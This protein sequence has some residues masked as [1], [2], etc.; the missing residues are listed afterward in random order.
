[1]QT[2]CEFFG[3]EKG[4]TALIGGGGKTSTMFALTEHLKTKGSVILCTT[5]HILKPS[6]YPYFAY[7]DAPLGFGQVVST[8][9]L[10]GN[11]LTAPQ[12]NFSELLTLADYVL[13][14]ADGSRQL[15][16]KAH[17]PHEPVIPSEA[18]TVLAIVGV[19]GIGQ[20]IRIAAHRPEIFAA[21]C[22]AGLDDAATPERIHTVV[23]TYPHVDG[24]ILNKADNASRLMNAETL[25][26]QFSVPVAITAWQTESPIKSYRRNA[27]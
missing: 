18:K 14:E 2:F 8:G 5:T 9:E 26:A 22:H 1:M 19:D 7:I 6:D 24:V 25:A 15:P 3:I 4:L 20:L 21:L 10:A 23:S 17:A 16:L 27:L 11:K 13:V 12:Q